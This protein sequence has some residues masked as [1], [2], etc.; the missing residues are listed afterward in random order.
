MKNSFAVIVFL[1]TMGIT[2]QNNSSRFRIGLNA[3]IEQ[4]LSSERIAFTE[5]TGYSVEYDKSEL[6]I[7]PE[8]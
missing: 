4:N 3:G 2:A 6:Q 8:H 7:R 1:W 5:Y